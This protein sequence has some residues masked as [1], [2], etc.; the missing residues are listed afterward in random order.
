MALHASCSQTEGCREACLFYLGPSAQGPVRSGTPTA[1]PV[2]V[3][4]DRGFVSEHDPVTY[5][6]V[7]DQSVPMDKGDAETVDRPDR[8]SAW[9]SVSSANLYLDVKIILMILILYK[10][11]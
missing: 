1:A 3:D 7:D 5:S 9:V 8:Q 4:L 11:D 6:L 10:L 2:I